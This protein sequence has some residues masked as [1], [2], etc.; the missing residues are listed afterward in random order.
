MTAFDQTSLVA[1]FLIFCRIGACLSL[2]PG[3]STPRIPMRARLLASLAVT[4]ALAPSLIERTS[5]AAASA[6]PADLALA[7][8]SEFLIGATLGMLARVMLGAIET[9]AAAAAMS[10]G[11]SSMFMQRVEENDSLPELAAF[12]TLAATTLF[13]VT[14]QHFEILRA[15]ADSYGPYPVGALLDVGRGLDRLTQALGAAFLL[16][17]RLMS[18][19]LLFGLIANIAFA[20]LNRLV[21][22]IA[23]YFVSTPFVLFGGLVVAYATV[24]TLLP[25]FMQAMAALI[26]R[27]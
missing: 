18:P 21:P 24:D 17:F 16:A 13:F 11:M 20:L 22:Q 10:I 14:N 9:V 25:L 5:A 15:L 23:I 1:T 27:G 6:S 2:A 4:V 19:F 26:A 7:I 8:G 12:I 3:L